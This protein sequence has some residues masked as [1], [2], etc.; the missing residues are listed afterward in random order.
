M[1]SEPWA[2]APAKNPYLGPMQL[3]PGLEPYARSVHLP[4]TGLTVHL[5]E[6]GPVGA[7]PVLLVHGL[8]DEADTWRHLLPL[9]SEEYHVLAPD[10]PG[11]GRSDKPDVKYSLPFFLKAMA[12]LLDVLGIQRTVLV[13][14]SLGAGIAHSFALD[15]PERV[16]A[17][18]LIA[19]SLVMRV[20][21]IDV[22]TLLFLVPGLGKWLYNR[23]RRDP[24]AAFR[25]LEPYY[26]RLDAMPQ[27]DR[28]FLFQRVNER[29]WSDGQR[30]AFLSTLRQLAGSMRGLQ[31][32]LPRRLARLQVP[33]T[34]LW[35]DADRMASIDNGRALVDLQ[36]SARLEI[37]PDAGHNL[38]QEQ[39]GALA[40]T[41][42]K[43]TPTQGPLRS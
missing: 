42:R 10:L 41:I 24:Q 26:S 17:L 7:V 33:T 15:H 12:E 23:L 13:G 32:D 25:S 5:Y 8:G 31:R 28:D 4:A 14:H 38:Q 40:E 21:K 37:V 9:L 18:V 39:P 35:G 29:V 2:Q 6:S 16:Q 30:R 11:F 20:Q 3:W 19:G 22:A 1:T 27:A 43:L 36:P 34:V